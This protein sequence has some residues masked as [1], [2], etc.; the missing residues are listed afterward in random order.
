MAKKVTIKEQFTEVAEVL[1]GVDRADL[2]EFIEGRIA[3]LD[4]K[5]ENKKATEKQIANA[6]LTEKIVAYLN[7]NEGR[8]R[9]GELAKVFD[10]ST[11]HISA[12]L[13]KAVKDGAIKR[14]AE[15]KIAY[16]S[17]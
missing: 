2:A 5:S 8:Y 3:V 6:A 14:E 10:T 12:L 4:K 17:A 9:A 1:K 7:E 11:T 16:F 13:T 15:H